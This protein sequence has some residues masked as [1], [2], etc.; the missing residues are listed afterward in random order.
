MADPKGGGIGAG[1]VVG[2]KLNDS[3]VLYS[4]FS[5]RPSQ[6]SRAHMRPSGWVVR[7]SIPTTP[8]VLN[9]LSASKALAGPLPAVSSRTC[10]IQSPA[11]G[12]PTVANSRPP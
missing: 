4:V 6:K 10:L 11:G 2:V 8:Q 7:D 5:P 12:N 3:T 1:G 9:V